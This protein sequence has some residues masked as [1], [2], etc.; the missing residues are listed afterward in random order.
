MQRLGFLAGVAGRT[1]VEDY[2]TDRTVHTAPE[3]CIDRMVP[4]DPEGA[5][6]AAAALEPVVVEVVLAAVAKEEYAVEEGP[7]GRVV[8]VAEEVESAVQAVVVVLP[9]VVGAILCAVVQGNVAFEIAVSAVVAAAASAVLAEVVVAVAAPELELGQT[10]LVSLPRSGTSSG[11]RPF[12]S[13]LLVLV[14]LV[15]IHVVAD[16]IGIAVLAPV[17]LAVLSVER[18]S[19]S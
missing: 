3:D 14:H 8:A 4:A 5:F 12:V 2:R 7:V 9:L 1:R 17:V 18:V 16:R 15:A 11:V 10:Q 6:L 19:A 13:L